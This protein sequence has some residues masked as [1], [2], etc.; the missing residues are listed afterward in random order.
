[1]SIRGYKIIIRAALKEGHI[2]PLRW[3]SQ[4]KGGL[5]AGHD[6]STIRRPWARRIVLV[7]ILGVV[8]GLAVFLL[9]AGHQKWGD[10]QVDYGREAYIPWEMLQGKSLY[11]DL[12]YFNGPLSPVVHL[13]VFFLFGP[14]LTTLQGADL[15]VLGLIIFL[16][17]KI[18]RLVSDEF[19]AAAAIFLFIATSAFNHANNLGNYNFI[20][21]YSHEITHGLCLLLLLLFLLYRYAVNQN[22]FILATLGFVTGAAF[23]TKPEIALAAA[24]GVGLGLALI[25][26]DDAARPSRIS[27]RILLFLAMTLLLPGLAYAW[28]AWVLSPGEAARD[29]TLMWRL[30]ANHRVTSLLFYRK[31]LGTADL[32]HNLLIMGLSLVLNVGIFCWL[33]MLGTLPVRI[34]RSIMGWWDAGIVVGIVAMSLLYSQCFLQLPDAWPLILMLFVPYATYHIWYKTDQVTPRMVLLTALGAVALILALKIFFNAH[35]FHYGVFLLVPSGMLF[36]WAVT[37]ELPRRFGNN[38]FYRRITYV[39]SCFILV[40]VAWPCLTRT[41]TNLASKNEV[42]STPRGTMVCDTRAQGIPELIEFLMTQAHSGQTVAIMPEGAMLNFLVGLPNSTPYYTLM[43]PEWLL[44]GE[45]KILAAYAMSPPDWIVLLDK[46]LDEYGMGS[47]T[48]GYGRELKRWIDQHYK[49]IRIFTQATSAQ[50]DYG[51]VLLEH[52]K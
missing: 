11:R 14:S 24:G 43:P 37:C 20:A 36:V 39:A 12:A 52:Q 35:L 3:L 28:L 40:L 33:N 23:L 1:M 30:A 21:P 47:F 4:K 15:I 26:R 5:L 46:D 25:F 8:T 13:L 32:Q 18:M 49:P 48:L 16:I 29:L 50:A 7:T 42:V 19:T 51:V 22:C 27:R 10:F 17:W 9:L 44:F 45:E 38:P 34:K 2:A 31:I 41:M 6:A